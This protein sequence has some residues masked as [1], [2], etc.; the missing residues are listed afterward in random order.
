MVVRFEVDAYVS[1][2]A[3]SMVSSKTKGDK[4]TLRSSSGVNRRHRPGD[5]SSS[6]SDYHRVM[7]QGHTPQSLVKII[8][9][10]TLVPQSSILEIKSTILENVSSIKS[11]SYT[12]LFFSQT[13]HLYIGGH[14]S[15]QFRRI[16][17]CS[18]T[19]GD[20]EEQ[21]DK[22]MKSGALQ[23]LV[24]ALRRIQEL[25]KKEGKGGR[26]ALIFE[27]KRLR[28]YQR[29]AGSGGNSLPK[30]IVARFEVGREDSDVR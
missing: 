27:E 14:V 29:D 18:V 3:P 13:P 17:E 22:L 4:M 15:G 21:H 12:Q 8:H 7:P 1:L 19:E 11:K 24:V 6:L 20:F 2:P 25:V 26:L 9:A 28:V 10:G 5:I 16:L 30:D 23:K